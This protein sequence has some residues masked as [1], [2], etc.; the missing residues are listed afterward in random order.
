MVG[1]R[2][3]AVAQVLH[4]QTSREGQRLNASQSGTAPSRRAFGAMRVYTPWA[5]IAL[6]G[7]VPAGN[8]EHC[9]DLAAVREVVERGRG[10]CL[11]QACNTVEGFRK[12]SGQQV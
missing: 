10:R 8:W 6:A 7:V 3:K 1:G 4:M 9:L 5:C 2:G 11:G 12:C